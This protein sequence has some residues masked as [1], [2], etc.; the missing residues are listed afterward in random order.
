MKHAIK[1]NELINIITEKIST[2][3]RDEKGMTYIRN[4]NNPLSLD[5]MKYEK[6]ELNEAYYK[7]YPIE[8]VIKY[9]CGVFGNNILGHSVLEK[10]NSYLLTF[11]VPKNVN[12]EILDKAMSLCGY[13]VEWDG[14]DSK[15][16]N[17]FVN[18]PYVDIQ[19]APRYSDK[20]DNIFKEQ[21]C[22]FHIC[23]YNF[24]EKI[25]KIGLVP[26]SK[27]NEYKYPNRIYLFKSIDEN[28]HS[29]SFYDLVENAHILYSA[30]DNIKNVKDRRFNDN[31]HT[32]SIFRVNTSMLSKD[33]VFYNDT[34]WGDDS[35]IW[36]YSNIPP[37]AIKHITDMKI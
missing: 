35:A 15:N 4:R 33:V 36:T 10:D 2:D 9:V 37:S 20:Q 27:N 31:R 34:T 18:K 25:M 19:Y 26:S 24:K 1:L 11:R 32:W 22:L 8:N 23:P 28:G 21:D 3:T 14:R 12:S 16:L 30:M 17:S 29:L 6:G 7:T 13:Y 5:L